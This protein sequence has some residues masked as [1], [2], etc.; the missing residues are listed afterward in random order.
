MQ[1]KTK[2]PYVYQEFPKWANGPSGKVIVN[3]AAEEAE[4]LASAKQTSLPLEVAPATNPLTD[5]AKVQ[6]V[7]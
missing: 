2:V 3:S 4:L 1:V 7:K 6:K 5:T